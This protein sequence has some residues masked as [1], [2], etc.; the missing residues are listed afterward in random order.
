MYR[1][2]SVPANLRGAIEV[3]QEKCLDMCWDIGH[4][5]IYGEGRFDLEHLHQ[6]QET[7]KRAEDICQQYLDDNIDINEFCRRTAMQD[8]VSCLMDIRDFL[9]DDIIIK[10]RLFKTEEMEEKEVED[11]EDEDQPIINVLKMGKA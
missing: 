11:S 6:L 1:S 5:M 4:E 10:Y 9:P 7:Y 2:Y 8:M 3:M